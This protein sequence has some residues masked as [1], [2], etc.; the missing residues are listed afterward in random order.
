MNIFAADDAYF[1]HAA[2]LLSDTTDKMLEEREDV[3]QKRAV[4][5]KRPT[6]SALTLTHSLEYLACSNQNTATTFYQ[7]SDGEKN[8]GRFQ[9]ISQVHFYFVNST[10]KSDFLY[11]FQMRGRISMEKLIVSDL[12]SKW[13]CRVRRHCKIAD[14]WANLI[15]HPEIK[16]K[17]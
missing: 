2:L 13:M 4:N 1:W 15:F 8:P 17:T 7:L 11:K 6:A 14:I 12:K 16:R 10:V 5:E 9:C 3:A